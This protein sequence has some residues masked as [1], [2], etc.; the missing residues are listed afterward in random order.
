M[1]EK[2]R[3]KSESRGRSG[4]VGRLMEEEEG[5]EEG[6]VICKEKRLS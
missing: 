4:A 6:E 2:K 1:G 3:K 5:E